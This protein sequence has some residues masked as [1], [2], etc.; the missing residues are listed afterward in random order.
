MRGTLGERGKM[1]PNRVDIEHGT[2]RMTAV[3]CGVESRD[4]WA[5]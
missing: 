4:R 1:F 5:Q 3:V 2:P